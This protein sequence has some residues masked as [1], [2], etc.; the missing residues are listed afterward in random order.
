M[1]RKIKLKRTFMSY[2]VISNIL[3]NTLLKYNVKKIQA[4][5]WI[6]IKYVAINYICITSP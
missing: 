4:K 2:H 5:T 1:K 6:L 3:K